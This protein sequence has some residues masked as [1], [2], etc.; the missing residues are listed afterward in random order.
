MNYKKNGAL[1]YRQESKERGV[2]HLAAWV[3]LA[4]LEPKMNAGALTGAWDF[5]LKFSPF[6]F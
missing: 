2:L 4:Q 1:L 5:D 3:T 6:A